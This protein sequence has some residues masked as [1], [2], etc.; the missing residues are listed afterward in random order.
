MK[1]GPKW[2][3]YNV[4]EAALMLAYLSREAGWRRTEPRDPKVN[5]QRRRQ[6]LARAQEMA[7]DIKARP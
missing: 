4:N 2:R 6:L 5:S 1:T 7:A 3:V